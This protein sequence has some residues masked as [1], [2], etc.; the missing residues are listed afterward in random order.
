MQSHVIH[1]P[2]ACMTLAR[3]TL[4]GTFSS[5]PKACA[6]CIRRH[7]LS[8]CL[9]APDVGAHSAL[10]LRGH[11]SRDG[12]I[13]APHLRNRM[14]VHDYKKSCVHDGEQGYR[15]WWQVGK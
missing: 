5:A 4:V 8:V 13:D 15:H 10:F 1:K 3:Y 12:M 6:I 7:A 11:S 14:I 9:V 2:T